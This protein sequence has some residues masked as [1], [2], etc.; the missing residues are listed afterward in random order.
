MSKIKISYL[1][2][3]K[4]IEVYTNMILKGQINSL[5]IYGSA[6]I[7]KDYLVEQ[8]LENNA[9]YIR[10]GLKGTYE[11]VRTLYK[12]RENKTIVFSDCDSIFKS[13]EQKNI[14]KT[15]LE[16]KEDRTIHYIDS[17]SKAIKDNLPDYFHFSSNIIVISNKKKFDEAY[18]SR[19]IPI[20]IILTNKEK[21]DLIG[22]N[23]K[24]FMPKIPI[25]FKTK[26]YEYIYS[27]RKDIKT[28]DYRYMKHCMAAYL[29]QKEEGEEAWQRWI[30]AILSC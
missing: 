5:L 25:E 16:D 17:S 13:V 12:Y 4:M 27:I 22:K 18:R 14:L 11:L 1:E 23:L 10:G 6:G 7:G 24:E 26:V 9:I 28:I 30:Q 29:A 21:L 19:S 15:A 8:V 20:E 2:K 3:F